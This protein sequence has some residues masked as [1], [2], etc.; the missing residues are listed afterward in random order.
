MSNFFIQK[1]QAWIPDI[2]KIISPEAKML[3]LVNEYCRCNQDA[4]ADDIY[5]S[6]ELLKAIVNNHL[7]AQVKA[8][9]KGFLSRDITVH[10]LISHRGDV[11]HLFPK[12]T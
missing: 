10:D 1:D 7:A 5:E 12:I 3:Q 6:L 9:D 8:N 2:A 4:N 11:H